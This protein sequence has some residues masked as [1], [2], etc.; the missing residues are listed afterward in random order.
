MLQRLREQIVSQIDGL[1]AER[2]EDLE[3]AISNAAAAGSA[4]IVSMSAK[5]SRRVEGVNMLT[6]KLSFPKDVVR[7]NSPTISVDENQ[8][9]L[10]FPGSGARKGTL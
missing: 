2:A 10:E 4:L 6:V 7:D 8:A 3:D 5:I 9:V 1:L